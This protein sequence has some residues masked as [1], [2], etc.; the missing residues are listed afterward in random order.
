M[1]SFVDVCFVEWLRMVSFVD[2]CFVE[3]LRM[4]SFVGLEGGAR[5]PI[6]LLLLYGS[7]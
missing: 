2:V 7:E 4:V 3:W 5:W 1:V 6:T